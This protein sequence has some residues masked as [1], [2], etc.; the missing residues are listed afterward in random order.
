[1]LYLGLDLILTVL[2]V[3]LPVSILQIFGLGLM[4]EFSIWSAAFWYQLYSA[5]LNTAELFV[6]ITGKHLGEIPRVMSVMLLSTLFTS[7]WVWLYAGAGLI[8]RVTYPVLKSL[9]WLTRHL[10]VETHPVHAMGM[11]LVFLTSLGFAL[12]APFVL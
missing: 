1:M 2:C 10:N 6:A 9:D 11:L 3:I 8:L 4:T 7:V 5:I 12:S